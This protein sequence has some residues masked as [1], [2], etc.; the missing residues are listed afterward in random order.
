MSAAIPSPTARRSAQGAKQGESFPHRENSASETGVA[1]AQPSAEDRAELLFEGFFSELDASDSPRLVIGNAGDH[2]A[3]HQFLIAVFQG[4][5]SDGFLATLDDPFYEP[6]D[7]VLVKQRHQILAHVHLTRRAIHFGELR[8]PVSGIW[9][10]ATLP[11]F[12]GQGFGQALLK[13]VDQLMR[14]DGSA[15]GMLKTRIP[16]FFRSSGWAVCGRHC[17]ATAS[18]RDLLA[19]ISSHRARRDKLRPLT[20][21][22]WRQVEL[23][24]VMQLYRQQMAHSYGS[25]ERTEN[26]WRWLIS[27]KHFD[28]IFVALDGPDRLEL[29]P[30]RSPIVGYCITRDDQIVELVAAS[31]RNDV[32]EALVARACSE[33]IERDNHHIVLHAPANDPL[34]RLFR[35][36]GGSFEHRETH[37]GEL[38]MVKLLEPLE[39][40]RS[41]CPELHRRADA[42]RLARPCELGLCIDDQRFR[43]VISRRSVKVMRQK[44]GRSYLSCNSAEFT[45]LVLGH[46]DLDEALAQ[47]RLEASTQVARSIASVLFAQVPFWRPPLDELRL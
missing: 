12:R 8:F 41:L 10:L 45:R 3:I 33:A 37:Q 22:P 32:R 42:A 31:G 9:S 11:E 43:L 24:A 4:L 34:Q 46:L 29:D 26:Y 21:R 47:G 13:V 16:H 5:R 40:L 19:Q 30:E 25:F 35:V 6:S 1:L 28:Q 23:S 36:A 2:A 15:L 7:R 14:E 17:T 27:R 18:T 39:F 20:I 44:V 38:L